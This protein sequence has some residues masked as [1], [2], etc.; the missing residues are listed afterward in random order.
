MWKA[1]VLVRNDTNKGLGR[2]LRVTEIEFV[3]WDTIEVVGT[4]SHAGFVL[5]EGQERKLDLPV[6]RWKCADPGE[7]K[8]GILVS[9]ELGGDLLSN[10]GRFAVRF[11]EL[12]QVLEEGTDMR[13]RS[14][15][16]GVRVGV[17]CVATE[18]TT[19]TDNT[20]SEETP[21]GNVTHE[22]ST[23][24][25]EDILDESYGDAVKIMKHPGLED[26]AG[27]VTTPGVVIVDPDSDGI[28]SMSTVIPGLFAPSVD[29]LGVIAFV[30]HFL[31]DQVKELFND[32][33]FECGTVEDGRMLVCPQGAE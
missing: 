6:P 26:L 22:E 29:M 25:V 12:S 27:V 33:V 3:G 10:L 20:T 14:F 2:G 24:S 32:S 30:T 1:D 23:T 13:R 16:V 28:F 11:F 19:T 8:Y 21:T 7:G 4:D 5:A 9:A 18:P 15:N 31:L 17:E